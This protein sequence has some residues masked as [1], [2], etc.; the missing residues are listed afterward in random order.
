MWPRSVKACSETGY[1]E[2]QNVAVEYHWQRDNTV[3]CRR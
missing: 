2:G 1:I 3:G